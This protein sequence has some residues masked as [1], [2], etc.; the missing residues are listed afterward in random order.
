MAVIRSRQFG[1]VLLLA[2][3]LLP[4]T[5]AWPEPHRFATVPALAVGVYRGAEVGSV[6]YIVIQLDEDHLGRGPTVLFSEYSRGSAVGDE[7]KEGVQIA[8]VAAA[9]AVREDAKSWRVTIKNRAYANYTNG[10]SASSAIAVGL[11][12]AWRGDV[13]RQDAVLTGQITPE[14]RIQ[15]VDSLPSKLEGAARANM[16]TVLIPAGQGRTDEWDLVE[17][18]RQHNMTVIEVGTLSEAYEFMA[19]QRP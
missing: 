5:A 16:Q 19:G 3:L 15:P 8:I 7:W 17:L 1:I 6:H 9:R 2:V 14:G 4:V 18:G 13:L 12:A 10:A 11:I